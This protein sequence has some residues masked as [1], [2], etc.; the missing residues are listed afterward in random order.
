MV[1]AKQVIKI[2]IDICM[3][4]LL[5]VLMAFHY[6]GLKWHEI[7]GTAMI[8]LFILHHILNWNWY[9]SLTKGKYRSGR[10]LLTVTDIV[11]LVDMF[12][13]MFSGIAMSRYVFRFLDLS[14]SKAWARQIHMTASYASFLLMGF[15]IGLHYG[16]IIGMIKKAFSLPLR[17]IAVFIAGYGAYALYTRKFMDY[18]SQKVMFA[19]F[20]YEEPIIY[21]ILDYIAIM[22][23]MIF[24]AYYLQRFLQFHSFGQ[25]NFQVQDRS[26]IGFDCCQKCYSQNSPEGHAKPAQY[27]A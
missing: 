22:G 17:G 19:F 2:V 3:T 13:L 18:I 27:D 6:V 23:L 4:I 15:H 21:F 1:K 8:V 12:L 5:F 24:L 10:I 26:A 20:D 11:L 16:L 14:V 25:R 9:R 7:T